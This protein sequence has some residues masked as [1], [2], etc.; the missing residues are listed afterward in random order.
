MHLQ[1]TKAAS[2]SGGGPQY[3]F[4]DLKD[5]VKDWLRSRGAC[6]VVLQTPYGIARSSFMAV[7]RDHK[8]APDG[9]AIKGSVGH[10]RI[11]QAG[12]DASIGEAIRH[13]YGIRAGRDF[14]T[15]KV[16]VSIH[17]DGHFILVPLAAKMRTFKREIPL[18]KVYA[19]L[20]LHRDYQS[21]FWKTQIGKIFACDQEHAKWA[22]SQISAIVE[23]HHK[24]ANPGILESDLLRAAGALAV[25]G[26]Y[27]G[28]YLG[29]GYDCLASS[30]DFVGYPRY[31]CPVEIKKRS[32]G[33]TYQVKKYTK[34]PRVV[35]LCMEHD[36]VNIP[37]HV[38]VIE[39][40]ALAEY[41]AQ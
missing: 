37:D 21:K 24:P 1:Q 6:P 39:L 33:F 35:V 26:L 3:Y 9:T 16:D 40:R 25:L 31:E 27:L 22:R 20:T 32:R 30:F 29:V 36:L 28:P 5:A 41:L 11:Q 13:W 15:I 23:D 38:D 10:D 7:D 34:L 18:E 14:E 8:L 2:R 4:H 12:G 19:P 17:P